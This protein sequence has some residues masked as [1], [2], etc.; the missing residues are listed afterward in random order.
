M[1][2]FSYEII[3]QIKEASDSS[4]VN[5]VIEKSLVTLGGKDGVFGSKRKYMMNM[6]MALRYVNAEGL[7]PKASANVNHAIEVFEMLRK[8]S[9]ARLF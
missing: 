3:N 2:D 9:Y 6:V 4:Q 7:K 8:K 5:S 1:V